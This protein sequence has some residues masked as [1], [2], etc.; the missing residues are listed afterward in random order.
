MPENVLEK[1]IKKKIEI[2]ENSKKN[3]SINSLNDL[4][5]KNKTFINFKEKIKKISKKKSFQLL[6][7]LK[8]LVLLLV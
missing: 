8:K 6:L 2:I 3:V 7:R 1:I 5:G 4:I